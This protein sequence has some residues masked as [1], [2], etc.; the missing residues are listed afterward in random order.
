MGN[1]HFCKSEAET[2]QAQDESGIATHALDVDCD[3]CGLYRVSKSFIAYNNENS[4]PDNW[5][6]WKVRLQSRPA[7]EKQERIYIS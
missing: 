4:N 3:K 1:C 7:N 2:Q 5:V 6:A